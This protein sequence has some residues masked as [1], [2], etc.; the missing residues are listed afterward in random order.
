MRITV[1]VTVSSASGVASPI[2]RMRNSVVVVPA[3]NKWPTQFVPATA[4]IGRLDVS[5]LLI[6]R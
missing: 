5:S 2:T 3:L 1:T 4:P 6:A